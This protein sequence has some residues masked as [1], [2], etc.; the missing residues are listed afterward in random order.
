MVGYGVYG[1]AIHSRLVDT[2]DV[3]PW[4]RKS[5]DL[6]NSDLGTNDLLTALDG[7]E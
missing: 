7:V 3:L 6:K 5:D 2:F 1:K 4:K